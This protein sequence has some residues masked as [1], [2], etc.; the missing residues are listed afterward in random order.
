MAPPKELPPKLLALIK[1][2]Q[3]DASS[4]ICPA[5]DKKGFWDNAKKKADGVFKPTSPDY[6]CRNKECKGSDPVK[7]PKPYAVWLPKRVTSDEASGDLPGDPASDHNRPAVVLADA[8]ETEE[9][10]PRTEARR[11]NYAAYKALWRD[12][13]EFQ[14]AVCEQGD[15]MERIPFDAAS[16]NAMA[17]AVA[18]GWDKLGLAVR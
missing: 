10:D 4:V 18:I 2:L 9:T 1:A 7:D 13:A 16:I 17:A 15:P 14:R 11:R 8:P 12:C 3:T 6:V 5:C